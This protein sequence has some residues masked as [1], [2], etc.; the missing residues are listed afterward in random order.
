MDGA[1][2]FGQGPAAAVSMSNESSSIKENRMIS[3]T[4][5]LPV[6]TSVGFGSFRESQHAPDAL[7]SLLS[8]RCVW[9]GLS[10]SFFPALD[11]SEVDDTI[12]ARVDIPGISP[13]KIDIQVSRDVLRISGERNDEADIGRTCHWTER[14]VGR[15]SRTVSLPWPV[16]IDRVTARYQ[17][18]VLTISLPKV[19]VVSSHRV[20][21]K[22]CQA[23][24]VNE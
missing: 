18:G 13:E 8:Q 22:V 5:A 16:V 14:P 2:R 17:G 1:H 19:A 7:L 10:F 20:N 15:F 21:V 9:K 11:L 23:Q 4:L 6:S 3:E 12:Q 24:T